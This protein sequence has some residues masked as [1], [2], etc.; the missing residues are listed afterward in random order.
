MI[1]RG[2]AKSVSRGSVCTRK[3]LSP[4]LL[5][6][7]PGFKVETEA[8]SRSNVVSVHRIICTP[9]S[10][11]GLREL[12]LSCQALL[13]LSASIHSF[14]RLHHKISLSLNSFILCPPPNP[15]FSVWEVFGKR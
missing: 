9:C 13:W 10:L 3:T 15:T 6:P 11:P 12:A 1:S 7:H 4:V 8:E 5:P 14:R 2:L